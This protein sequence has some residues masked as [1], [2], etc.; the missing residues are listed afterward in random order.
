MVRHPARRSVLERCLQASR[1]RNTI[2]TITAMRPTPLT[3][4]KHDALGDLQAYSAYKE[5]RLHA[6]SLERALAEGSAGRLK[7][8]IDPDGDLMRLEPVRAI[9]CYSRRAGLFRTTYVAEVYFESG[10]KAE[11]RRSSSSSA[12]ACRDALISA[13]A[14]DTQRVKP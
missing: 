3:D 10:Y 4:A 13:L 7:Y 9:N 14:P 5:M 12:L 2:T 8:F 1:R 11:Y 6:E